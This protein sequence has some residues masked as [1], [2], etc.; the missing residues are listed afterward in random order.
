MSR[1][2][3]AALA[4]AAVVGLGATGCASEGTSQSSAPPPSNAEKLSVIDGSASAEDFQQMLD[5]LTA[6]GAPG[7][8]TEQEVADTMVASWQQ[9]SKQDSLY[10]FSQALASLYNC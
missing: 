1:A 3:I 9:S 4:A 6:S 2:S 8:E 10:D 5:C 7:T